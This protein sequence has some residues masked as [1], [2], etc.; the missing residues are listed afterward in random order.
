[1]EGMSITP[2]SVKA[3]IVGPISTEPP[4]MPDGAHYKLE[5]LSSWRD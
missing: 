4:L 2:S 5:C 1:V 3:K